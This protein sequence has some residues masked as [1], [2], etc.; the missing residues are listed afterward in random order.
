M[1]NVRDRTEIFSL[2][3]AIRAWSQLLTRNME[4]HFY[5]SRGRGYKIRPARSAWILAVSKM[6]EL[7]NIH[8][9]HHHHHHRHSHRRRVVVIIT[10]IFC[11]ISHSTF[12]QIWWFCR[13]E[14]MYRIEKMGTAEMQIYTKIRSSPCNSNKIIPRKGHGFKTRWNPDIFFGLIC[15]C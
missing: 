6:G 3:T 11:W 7:M 12:T 2:E 4:V 8:H 5:P 10:I 14:E 9:H 15:S 1:C 13:S